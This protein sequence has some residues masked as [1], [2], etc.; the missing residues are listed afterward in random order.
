MKI[1]RQLVRGESTS[2]DKRSRPESQKQNKQAGRFIGK[3]ILHGR[4]QVSDEDYMETLTKLTLSDQDYMTF[5]LN[6]ESDRP[7][8]EGI[9]IKPK[10][11]VSKEQH[12]GKV[13]MMLNGQRGNFK[14]N[15]DRMREIA[16]KYGVTVV[17]FNYTQNATQQQDHVDD[18]KR[19]MDHIKALSGK[20]STMAKTDSDFLLYGESYGNVVAAGVIQDTW[21]ENLP[22]STNNTQQ[23]PSAKKTHLFTN[24]GWGL[25]AQDVYS[26]VPDS[27]KSGITA[28][29]LDENNSPTANDGVFSTKIMIKDPTVIVM[30][31]P[32]ANAH[33]VKPHALHGKGKSGEQALSDAIKQAFDPAHNNKNG[34]SWF[35]SRGP[36]KL[37]SAFRSIV[38]TAASGTINKFQDFKDNA[39]RKFKRART[40]KP[41]QSTP[42]QDRD[43]NQGQNSSKAAKLLGEAVDQSKNQE[44]E[45]EQKVSAKAAK[46]LGM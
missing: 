22:A 19:V 43:L 21:A 37:S 26:R 12:P 42:L 8:V 33:N 14:N 2:S 9:I 34:P 28:C 39:S 29:S 4:A 6:Q 5:D 46:R 17:S 44:E 20:D 41:K 1:L 27:C 32:N 36:K 35:M 45:K 25:D 10:A 3:H 31:T 13:V 18:A 40:A 38:K 15:I 7:S 11:N 23:Q 16:N 24:A 30:T